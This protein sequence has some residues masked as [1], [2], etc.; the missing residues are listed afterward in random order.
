MSYKIKIFGDKQNSKLQ[1]PPTPAGPEDR[2]KIYLTTILPGLY[3]SVTDKLLNPSDERFLYIPGKILDA[4]YSPDIFDN[5]VYKNFALLRNPILFE[6][7]IFTPIAVDGIVVGGLVCGENHSNPEELR[8]FLDD[9]AVSEYFNLIFNINNH[10][11]AGDSIAVQ[12]LGILSCNKSFD[13]FMRSMS[14][15]LVEFMGGGQASFYYKSRNEFV[16]RKMAGQITYYEEMPPILAGENAEF[17]DQAISNGRLFLPA[18]IVPD[19]VAE[20]KS[21]PA[22]RF[23]LGGEAG[24]NNK[25]L[26]T[27]FV[28]N[29][30]SYSFALFFGRLKQIL[31]GLNEKHFSSDPDWHQVFSTLDGLIE[32]ERSRQ[33]I[34]EFLFQTLSESVNINRLRIIKYDWLENR[35]EIEGNAGLAKGSSS[36]ESNSIPIGGSGLESLIETGEYLFKSNLP[37]IS[38]NRIEYQA[39]RNGSRSELLLPIKSD[40]IVIGILAVGSPMCDENLKQHAGVLKTTANYLGKLFSQGEN[41]K[42]IEIYTNQAEELQS[43]LASFENLKILGELAGKA[44]HDLNNVM[45]AILGR[46]QLILNKLSKIAD[47]ELAAKIAHDAELIEKSAIDAGEILGRLGRLSLAKKEIRQAIVSILDVI[48]DSIEIVR[49]RWE[50]LSQEKHIKITLKKDVPNDIKILADPAGLREVLTNL[51]LSALDAIPRGGEI[52]ASCRQVNEMASIVI[53]YNGEGIDK[54]S[55]P[56]FSANGEE[57]TGHSL[58]NCRE[59]IEAHNGGIRV[60][61]IP[62]EGAKFVIELPVYR[63][64][65]TA[66]QE[67]HLQIVRKPRPQ[68]LIAEDSSEFKGTLQEALNENGFEVSS[69]PSGEQA[70]MACG[71][72]IFDVLIVDLGLPG[73]NGLELVAQIRSFDKKMKIILISGWEIEQSISELQSKGVD[74]VITKPFKLETMLETLENLTRRKEKA[75]R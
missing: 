55:D 8:C 4:D 72:T 47:S 66:R 11:A 62:G 40:N 51:F 54:V 30:T 36:A 10:L 60:N 22:I 74:S 63:T 46:G 14:D 9:F 37:T 25:Y 35:L 56:F 59:I 34:A 15:W 12:I 48:N 28:P 73:I 6:G 24:E 42:T 29:F 5:I 65:E 58:S 70:I 52:R 38:S 13:R 26:L 31:A 16:L 19:Y 20:L 23:I 2:I 3:F 61:W 53:A 27:G 49:P 68:I 17:Y 69:A 44:V 33:E 45:G 64:G 21:P 50:R 7:K 18:G 67:S 1:L 39:F 57:G 71:R 43:K 32:G 41:R 75:E